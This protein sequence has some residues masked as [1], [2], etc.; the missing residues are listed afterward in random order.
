[1][2]SLARASS[3]Q[4]HKKIPKSEK[5]ILGSLPITPGLRSHKGWQ[6]TDE[7]GESTFL[8][9]AKG[10]HKPSFPERGIRACHG[11]LMKSSCKEIWAL[12]DPVE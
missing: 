8:A 12:Q 7:V 2:V 1:M 5:A 10:V 6:R 3:D 11:I 9:F 4:S